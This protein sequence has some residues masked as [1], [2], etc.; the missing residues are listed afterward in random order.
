MKTLI[1]YYSRCGATKKAAEKLRKITGEK[2]KIYLSAILDLYDRYPIAYVISAK[3]QQS[4][5]I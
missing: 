3:K 4:S 5:C 1:V 2:K